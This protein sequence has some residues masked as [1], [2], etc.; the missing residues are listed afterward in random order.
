VTPGSTSKPGLRPWQTA[1]LT[2]WR[3][4]GKR[5]I[6]AAATGTGKTRLAIEALSG[7]T[8]DWVGVI[9]VPTKALQSQW[10]EVLCRQLQTHPRN[11][12]TIGGDSPKYDV[13]QRFLVAILNS[14]KDRLPPL[15]E[16]W[17]QAGRKTLLVVD[18]CHRAG[19][20]D[21]AQSLWSTTY[22]ATLGLSATPE[23]GDDGLDEILIPALGPVIYRYPLR[24]ALDDRVL[25]PLTVA[26]LYLDLNALEMAA[27]H[28]IEGRI[29]RWVQSGA[30]IGDPVVQRL[31]A[32][33][34]NVA[35]RA[36]GRQIAIRALIEGG[37]LQG[38]RSILFHETIDQAQ[39]T[40]DT[41]QELDFVYA[42]E[43]SKLPPEARTT[44]L[45]R[46]SSGSVDI[47]ITVRALDEGIDVP[48]ANTAVIVSGN[49]NPR[50]RIQRA[51]RIIRPSGE[52][53]LLVS[54]FARGTPEEM[55]VGA[56][57]ADLFGSSRVNHLAR[58]SDRDPKPLVAYLR[59]LVD[60]GG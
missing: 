34:A 45:R 6:V 26:N 49:M 10:V 28:A 56:N 9:V 50:Q 46:F 21:G 57:D 51:G 35:R 58:W 7:L 14:A 2:E 3:A 42:I 11:V 37:L 20:R 4:A 38:R 33:Q 52:G 40:A 47:L 22:E 31:R 29:E 18:E 43:H 39:R 44:G 59:S 48:D 23:R 19:A 17:R 27:Y 53:S 24:A 16:H 60:L 41:L 5:G 8:D 25:A 36:S 12:G 15:V 1:A 54:L 55:Q 32:E 13:G 30:S